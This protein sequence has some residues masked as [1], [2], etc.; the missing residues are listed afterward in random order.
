VQVEDEAD[1]KADALALALALAAKA[2]VAA[3]ALLAAALHAAR[4]DA[5]HAAL[6]EAVAFAVGRWHVAQHVAHVKRASLIALSHRR[7]VVSTGRVLRQRQERLHLRHQ[8]A[9]LAAA[10]ADLAVLLEVG[11]PRLAVGCLW[12]RST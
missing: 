11:A 6:H 12:W 4:S 3:A 2:L 10:A 1:P 5:L 8:P 9:D 7:R